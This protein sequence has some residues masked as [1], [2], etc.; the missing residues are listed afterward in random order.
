MKTKN[1]YEWIDRYLDGS[2]SENEKIEFESDLQINNILKS[3]LDK[4]IKIRQLWSEAKIYEEIRREVKAAFPKHNRIV[5]LNRKRIFSIAAIIIIL[6]GISSVLL[7]KNKNSDFFQQNSA[8]DTIKLDQMRIDKPDNK[9]TYLK[10]S[11]D[12][13][14]ELIFPKSEEEI[15]SQRTIKF[16]WL[17]KDSLQ[18]T[19]TLFIRAISNNQI[20][21]CQQIILADNNYIL[22]GRILKPGFYSWT[23]GRNKPLIPFKIFDNED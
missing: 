16:Q 19:D 1:K 5:N 9:A 6:I 13:K 21:I 18:L 22:L 15:E 20:T 10:L 14:I 4:R 7:L 12:N 11:P 8:Q 23:I 3:E 2:L 17:A